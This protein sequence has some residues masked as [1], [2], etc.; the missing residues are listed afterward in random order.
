MVT[1][2]VS[3]GSWDEEPALPAESSNRERV[4]EDDDTPGGEPLMQ[5]TGEELPTQ[6]RP[7]EEPEGK[8]V[9]L[10]E[11]AHEGPDTNLEEAVE[12][13]VLDEPPVVEAAGGVIETGMA[14]EPECPGVTALGNIDESPGA[15]WLLCLS[16][17]YHWRSI[18]TCRSWKMPNLETTQW[19]DP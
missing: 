10:E 14:G 12:V 7:K 18:R 16:Y 19:K 17:L 15:P 5:A 9:I 2:R 13:P 11:A 6:A 4:T 3:E 1:P 8:M